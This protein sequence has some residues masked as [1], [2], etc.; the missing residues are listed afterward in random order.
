MRFWTVR[1]WLVLLSLVA[2]PAVAETP[3]ARRLDALV[4]AAR[5]ILVAEAQRPSRPLPLPEPF[6][7]WTAPPFVFCVAMLA[8]GAKGTVTRRGGGAPLARLRER[9]E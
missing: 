9:S 3:H 5:E 4:D 8:G 1:R 6:R 2:A 7:C